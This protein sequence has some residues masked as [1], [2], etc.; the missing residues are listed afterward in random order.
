MLML[1]LL[2]QGL[3][4]TRAPASRC[5][6]MMGQTISLPSKIKQAKSDHKNVNFKKRDWAW[7]LSSIE[8]QLCRE[9]QIRRL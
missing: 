1:L 8:S 5:Y 7:W 6:V 9:A 3:R 4:Y 2:F